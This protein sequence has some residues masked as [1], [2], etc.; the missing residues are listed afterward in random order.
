V[1]EFFVTLGHKLTLGK[2]VLL[3]FAQLLVELVGAMVDGGDEAVGHG[4]DSGAEV[5]VL[6]EQVLGFLG[7]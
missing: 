6:E 1:G 3:R 2:D 7:G 4:M 5:V